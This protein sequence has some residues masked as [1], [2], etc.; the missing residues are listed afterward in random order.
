MPLIAW[1]FCLKQL[2]LFV[3]FHLPSL[4]SIG[5]CV[6]HMHL[7]SSSLS[8]KWISIFG[9]PYLVQQMQKRLCIGS[10]TPPLDV[11]ILFLKGCMLFMLLQ[12]TMKDSTMELEVSL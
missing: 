1:I 8:V 11:T 12:S 6:S 4:G 2:Q 9:T 7:C 10:Y 3:I 5:G